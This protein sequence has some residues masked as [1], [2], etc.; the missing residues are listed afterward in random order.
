MSVNSVMA[1]A[2]FF[3][4]VS[5]ASAQLED[6][7]IPSPSPMPSSATVYQRAGDIIPASIEAGERPHTAFERLEWNRARTQPV[8][9]DSNRKLA[10]GSVSVSELRHPLSK[11][12]AALAQKAQELSNAGK[13]A[14]AIEVL[15]QML[16]DSSSAGYARSL[17]GVEYLKMG[18][19]TGAIPQLKMAVTLMPWLAA[20]HSNLGFALCRT[21]DRQAG[22]AELIEALK[23]DSSNPKANFLLGVML[24]DKNAPEARNHLQVAVNEVSRARLALAVFYARLGEKGP[25]QAEVDAYVQSRSVVSADVE[26]FVAYAAA[27]AAPALAFGFPSPPKE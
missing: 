15:K 1:S 27:L 2:A 6:P 24:L 26:H 8:P 25:V 3:L 21:G 5:Q 12:G 7:L 13:H 9:I 23:L 20:N 11:A 19:I 10:A 16:T 17:L 4:C 22:E 14:E 18:D